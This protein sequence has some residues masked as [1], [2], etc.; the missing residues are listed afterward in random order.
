MPL[1]SNKVIDK[2]LTKLLK[3]ANNIRR[4]FVELH[5]CWPFKG[6]WEDPAHYLIRNSLKVHCGFE[7][8]NV[9]TWVARSIIRDQGR[10]LE[11]KRQR[12]TF[13]ESYERG[14][15][16]MNQVIYRIRSSHILPH[17]VHGF[18][19]L[20]H[21]LLQVWHSTWSGAPWLILVLHIFSFCTFLTLS[22]SFYTPFMTLP[23]LVNLLS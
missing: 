16:S 6:G 21:L 10:H 4:Y 5:S 19:H 20:I 15:S 13:D 8:C 17:L 18:P 7:S 2:Q 3:S 14:I 22:L 1:S 9:V 11:L 23:S 12:M